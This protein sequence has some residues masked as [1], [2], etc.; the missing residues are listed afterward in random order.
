[1]IQTEKKLGTMTA[2]WFR[3][4][5]RMVILNLRDIFTFCKTTRIGTGDFVKYDVLNSF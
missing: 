2:L 5:N 1:M 4:I 3:I